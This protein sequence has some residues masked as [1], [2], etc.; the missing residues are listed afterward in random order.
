MQGTG[1]AVPCRVEDCGDG[2]YDFVYV[3]RHPGSYAI[4]VIADT[5]MQSQAPGTAGSCDY[6]SDDCISDDYISDDYISDDYNSYA[7]VRIS[8]LGVNKT[9]AS[10][11]TTSVMTTSV[12]T[13]LAMTT[14]AMTISV[15]TTLVM[16]ASVMTASMTASVMPVSGS[17][18]SYAPTPLRSTS[19]HMVHWHTVFC[20][21]QAYS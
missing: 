15:M 21:K 19:V 4:E 13:T 20:L 2:T 5:L 11:M 18:S 8:V 12:M 9:T 1:E 16:T 14:S 7:C 6:I 10:V 3:P 17:V